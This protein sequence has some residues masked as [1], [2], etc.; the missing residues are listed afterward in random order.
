MTEASPLTEVAMPG[1]GDTSIAQGVEVAPM[2]YIAGPYG[3]KTGEKVDYNIQVAREAAIWLVRHGFFFSC[4]HLNSALFDRL[5][6]EIS[7]AHW[8][9]QDLRLMAPC[10]AMVLVGEWGK[11]KGVNK[12]RERAKAIGMPM[13]DLTSVEERESLLAWRAEWLET[14]AKV[15][16]P[17][18]ESPTI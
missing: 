3:D 1:A 14:V 9:A 8:Y 12:E 5:V 13:F 6:P 17:E 10:D 2:C 7:V 15:F 4:P 18:A 16:A 11:S